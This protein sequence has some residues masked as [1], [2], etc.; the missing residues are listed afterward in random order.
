MILYLLSIV[1]DRIIEDSSRERRV[2]WR[3]RDS[4]G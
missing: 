4:G 1:L 2:A 3:L